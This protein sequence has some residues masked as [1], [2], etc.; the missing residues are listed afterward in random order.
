M[1]IQC[2]VCGGWSP[3]KSVGVPGR[4][5]RFKNGCTDATTHAGITR[6]NKSR[7]GAP[8]TSAMS[9]VLAGASGSA[10]GPPSGP[11]SSGTGLAVAGSSSASASGASPPTIGLNLRV[12]GYCN[13]G[14]RKYMED[15]FSV[16]YQVRNYQFVKINCCF[17][18][19]IL[20]PR[21]SMTSTNLFS[22]C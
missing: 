9:S 17:R 22:A 6:P 12:T 3:P 1:N 8:K 18:A 14:G 19:A 10:M 20:F 7:G 13:Q 4:E 11:P 21:S 2:L 5:R 15:V 16:A